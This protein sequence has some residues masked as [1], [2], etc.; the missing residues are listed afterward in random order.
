MIQTNQD[1]SVAFNLRHAAE[2]IAKHALV[3]LH[4]GHLDIWIYLQDAKLSF[5]YCELK[6]MAPYLVDH[7]KTERLVKG[8]TDNQWKKLGIQLARVYFL[9]HGSPHS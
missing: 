8:L 3:F 5:H 6:P 2:A 1:D 7:F 9:H 4:G